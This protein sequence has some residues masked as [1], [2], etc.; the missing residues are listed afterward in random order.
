M[1]CS[2]F[3]LCLLM[4]FC[5]ELIFLIHDFHLIRFAAVDHSSDLAKQ[6]MRH[7]DDGLVRFFCCMLAVITLQRHIC[8]HSDPAGLHQ[9][10][11]QL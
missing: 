5:V 6:L 2:L 10:A 4:S 7:F 1:L 8:S 9:Q 11:P 3:L